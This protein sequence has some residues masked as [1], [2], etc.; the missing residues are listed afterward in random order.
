[1]ARVGPVKTLVAALRIAGDLTRGG[2]TLKAI[3]AESSFL[4]TRPA[5]I[6]RELHEFSQR[7]GLH[8]TQFE[9]GF[10]AVTRKVLRDKAT[11]GD[12][13]RWFFSM[14]SGMQSLVDAVAYTAARDQAL[15]DG[16]DEATAIAIGNQVVRDTQASGET[17]YQAHVLRGS[18]FKKLWT[19]FFGPMLATYNLWTEQMHKSRRDVGQGGSKVKAGGELA[20]QYAFLFLV[21]PAILTLAREVSRGDFGD[22]DDPERYLLEIG[23]AMAGTTFIA[24]DIAQGAAS[25]YGYEGPPGTRPMATAADTVKRVTGAWNDE[26]YFTVATEAA[27]GGL[28][29]GGAYLHMPTGS[30]MRA[31]RAYQAWLEGDL[32]TNVVRAMLFGYDREGYDGE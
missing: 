7:V 14:I 20:A 21:G 22:E 19:T 26:D 13:Q 27:G 23:L 15:A 10:D 12:V 1:M 6:N 30:A 18:T 17:A 28:S 16:K 5:T 8:Q 31:W 24:R 4:S 32:E 2:K 9:R 11:Y 29:I 25:V 3:R